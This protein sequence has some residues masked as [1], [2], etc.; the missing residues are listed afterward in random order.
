MSFEVEGKLYKIFDTQQV[1]NSFQKRE[2]VLNVDGQYPQLVAFQLVQ[3]KCSLI[4]DFR[5]NDLVKVYFDLRGR[6]WQSP[7]GE[8]K[9]FNSLN[10]WKVDKGAKE[11]PQAATGANPSKTTAAPSSVTNTADTPPLDSYSDDL[12]F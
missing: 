2:F 8:L 3:D 11:Q 7:Q 4:D 12:P 5:V 6:E 1:S 9:Y 10:A